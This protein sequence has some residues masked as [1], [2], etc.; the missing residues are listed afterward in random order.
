MFSPKIRGI[1]SAKFTDLSYTDVADAEWCM[2][3]GW[4]YE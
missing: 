1:V 3:D 4:V 2:D